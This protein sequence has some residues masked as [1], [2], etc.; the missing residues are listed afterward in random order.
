MRY[1]PGVCQADAIDFRQKPTRTR[2]NVGAVI[3]S[4]GI[5]PFDPSAR[6]EYGY[7]QYPNVVTSMDYER[8][9]SST[10][11]YGGEVRRGSDK[12][13]R[14]TSPGSSAWDPEG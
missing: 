11:P 9:L 2:I 8:L 10:G 4:S 13:T 1:L 6:E 14:K 12:N 7:S 3:L 5:T